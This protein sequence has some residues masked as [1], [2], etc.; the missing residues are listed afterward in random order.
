MDSNLF[1]VPATA[2]TSTNAAALQASLAS[3]LGANLATTSLLNNS[4]TNELASNLNN[5]GQGAANLANLQASIAN[6]QPN[7]NFVSRS[8]S[9]L[10]NDVAF[11]SNNAFGNSTFVNSRDFD[12]TFNR[13]DVDRVSIGNSAFS[14]NVVQAGNRQS[15]NG[16]RSSDTILIGNVS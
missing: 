13:S 5:F 10:E 6:V 11:S 3:G 8:L 7:N 16:S 9:K 2:L 12:S 14:T 1:I 4:L 15:S